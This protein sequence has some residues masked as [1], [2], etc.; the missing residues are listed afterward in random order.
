VLSLQT[1]GENQNS[2]VLHYEEFPD[3]EEFPKSA[4][5]KPPGASIP[6]GGC[7]KYLSLFVMK[8]SGK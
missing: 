5:M 3:Y 6:F 1:L 8:A 4:D 7:Q 2:E